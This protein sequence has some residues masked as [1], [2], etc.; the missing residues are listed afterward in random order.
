MENNIN[1][2][3]ARLTEVCFGDSIK[4]GLKIFAKT[5]SGK[6]SGVS[7]NIIS[8][9]FTLSEGDIQAEIKKGECSCKGYVRGWFATDPYLE[10]GNIESMVDDYW[11]SA[12]AD[13]NALKAGAPETRIWVDNTPAAQCGLLYVADLLENTDT[14]IR[15]I[16]LP[17]Q[18]TR[19]DG[20][21]V[22]YR[23]WG[24]VPPDEYP[25]FMDNER[26]LSS[27]EIAAF[28]EKWR[29]LKEQNAELRVIE[30]G[31]VISADISYYDDYIRA[32]FPDEPQKVAY[33]I[34][35]VLGKQCV[36]TG[37]WFIAERIKYF[38]ESGELKVIDDP[39]TGFYNIV[40]TH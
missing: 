13:L 27:D 9:P 11:E 14:S 30:N 38:I 34:G 10:Y 23:G 7:Q 29:K 36:P 19:D 15:V 22:K 2:K 40:V 24:E 20:I 17:G 35:R 25:T 3:S 31:E 21:I 33:I 18:I 1:S 28:A 37:D 26:Q 12:I 5:K 4:G 8:L 16:N 6:K 39:K 32:E